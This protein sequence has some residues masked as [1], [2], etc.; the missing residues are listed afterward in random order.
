MRGLLSAASRPGSH[1]VQRD[2]AGCGRIHDRWRGVCRVRRI[3]HRFPHRSARA[4]A[5]LHREHRYTGCRGTFAPQPAT[6]DAAP[7][8]CGVTLQSSWNTRLRRDGSLCAGARRFRNGHTTSR[9]RKNGSVQLLHDYG[10]GNIG[11]WLVALIAWMVA[12]SRDTISQAFFIYVL[13]FMI[14]AAGLTHSIAGS[15]EF[16]IGVF[17]GN[18]S[19]A[20]FL[21]GFLFPT[22][23]REHNRWIV[24]RYAA[25]LRAGHRFAQEANATKR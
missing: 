11:G 21:G 12:A 24:P 22:T 6:G 20:Q 17:A 1:L 15:S 25:Q 5:T 7:L 2:R 23:P 16:L 13:A 18:I 10:Q 8:G 3:P 4:G 19:W 14:P 9:S